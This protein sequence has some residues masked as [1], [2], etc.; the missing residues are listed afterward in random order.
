[1]PSSSLRRLQKSPFSSQL[2]LTAMQ[3][4]AGLLFSRNHI[5]LM[6]QMVELPKRIDCSRR[7]RCPGRWSSSGAFQLPTM[8]AELE[9]KKNCGT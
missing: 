1:M 3:Q 5:Y 9:R 8:G 2:R 6:Q 4:T 7:C